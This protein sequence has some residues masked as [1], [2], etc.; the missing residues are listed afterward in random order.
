MIS[1][2]ENHIYHNGKEIF[3][4]VTQHLQVAGLVDFSMVTRADLEFARLRGQHVH[5]AIN[6]YLYEDLD[7]D[8]LDG[9]YK[10]YVQAFIRFCKEHSFIPTS[11]EEIVYCDILRTAGTYDLTGEWGGEPAMIEIKTPA[12][13]PITTALQVSAYL[14][15]YNQN[16]SRPIDKAYGL[17]LRENGTYKL[18]KY[19][20][21]DDFKIFRNICKTN[22]W[23]LSNGI[24]PVGA[25]SNPKTLELC[26]EIVG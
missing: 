19:K 18:H 11:S 16:N 22:W 12:T 4:S 17:H 13:M 20:W 24:I 1:R 2:D 15:F 8:S 5:T 14:K 6:M 21:W 3:V 26:K 10:G 7:F 25:R 9:L 23:C